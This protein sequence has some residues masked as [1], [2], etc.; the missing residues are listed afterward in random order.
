MD[1]AEQNKF[2]EELESFLNKKL[3]GNEFHLVV[4]VAKE[5]NG[6]T[7]S[8]STIGEDTTFQNCDLVI[9]GIADEAEN[10]LEKF[11]IPSGTKFKKPVEPKW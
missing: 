7:L 1:L 6:F 10:L 9:S 3:K 2:S 8:K 4:A 5:K 11:K